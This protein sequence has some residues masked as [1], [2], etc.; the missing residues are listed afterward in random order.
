MARKAYRELS[1]A[2]RKHHSLSARVS[3]YVVIGAAILGVTMLIIGLALY[4]VAV[5]NQYIST[6]FNLCRSASKGAER[7]GGDGGP[8]GRGD[9]ALQ[10]NVGCR[11][12]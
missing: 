9:G 11:T 6:S 3:R 8:V 5:S 10:R 12:R 2:E 7:A 4:S 1:E